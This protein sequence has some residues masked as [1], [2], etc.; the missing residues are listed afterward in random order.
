MELPT[1]P[2]VPGLMPAGR[3]CQ[4]KFQKGWRLITLYFG[5]LA[6]GIQRTPHRRRTL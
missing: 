1:G 3:G 6:A 2:G 5:L 4:I